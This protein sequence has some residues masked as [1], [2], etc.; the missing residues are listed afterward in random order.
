MTRRVSQGLSRRDMIVAAASSA[1]VLASASASAAHAQP[2]ASARASRAP[3]YSFQ[4]CLNTSTIRGQQLDL[5][6][7]VELVIAAGYNAIE[8]W[9]NDIEKYRD[10]GGSLADLAKQCADAA[11]TIPSAI[12]FA[13]WIVDDDAARAAGLE[14]MKRDMELLKAMGGTRIAAPPVG[15][16]QPDAAKINLDAAAERYHALCEAGRE[17]GVVPQLE[18]WG[19]SVNL[20]RLAESIYVATASGH[21][22]ACLL[23]DVYHLFKGG[24]D[25]DGLKFLSRTA[26]HCFH[27]NDYPAGLDRADATDAHRVYPTDGAALLSDILRTFAASGCR[28]TLSLE[29]F[30]RDYWT[31]P[32]QDVAVTGLTKMKAV[33]AAAGLA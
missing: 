1:G 26:A 24:S 20:S 29:L 33:V 15:A 25:F 28:L 16:H 12:G 23:A 30:N 19:F 5:K 17:T 6:Q 14:R 3:D 32:A 31:Q 8:P 4:Y 2:A 21:A 27:M 13:Q 11:V 10:G 22:D 18:V 9:I 7:Q